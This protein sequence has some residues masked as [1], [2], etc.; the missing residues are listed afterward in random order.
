MSRYLLSVYYHY[1]QVLTL[2]ALSLCPGTYSECTIIMSKY[3]LCV[4][5][6]MYL[7]TCVCVCV[8]LCVYPYTCV[9][10]SVHVRM[11]PKVLREWVAVESDS[12]DVTKR[13][14]LHRMMDMTAD[15]LRAMGGNVSLVDVG[16]QEVSEEVL[17]VSRLIAHADHRQTLMAA[18]YC[19]F[20]VA[21]DPLF[22]CQ[23]VP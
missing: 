3:L 9:R 13:A 16:H 14:E 17:S 6:T 8:C 11:R 1:V 22:A 15:K 23:V 2:S 21:G 20:T 4:Y 10:V 18:R 19:H 5:Y 12:S 7:Y